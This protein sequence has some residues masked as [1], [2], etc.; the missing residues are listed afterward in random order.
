MK[1]SAILFSLVFIAAFFLLTIIP[2]EDLYAQCAMCRASVE[3]NI[4]N[5]GSRAGNG[6]N[7]GILYLLVMPY[8]LIGTVALLIY[9]KK[10]QMDA[11]KPRLS[12]YKNQD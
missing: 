9:R 1:S 8:L 6:L 2:A 7:T 11:K 12:L 4:N 10:K 5:G 3:N